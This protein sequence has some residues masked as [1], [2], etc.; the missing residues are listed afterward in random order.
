MTIVNKGLLVGFGFFTVFVKFLSGI[1]G[2]IGAAFGQQ[3]IAILFVKM[4]A[5]ALFV[6]TIFAAHIVALVKLDA[7]PVQRLHDVL[8]GTWHKAGLVGIFN[9]ENHLATVL[10]GKQIVI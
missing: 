6:G 8:L 10:L 1:E 9:A 5:V 2:D 4:F 3:F 7:T